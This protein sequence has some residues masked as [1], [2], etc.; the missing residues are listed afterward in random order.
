MGRWSEREGK[1]EGLE[2][3]LIFFDDYFHY[4]VYFHIHVTTRVI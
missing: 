1:I 4:F 3:F 2:S